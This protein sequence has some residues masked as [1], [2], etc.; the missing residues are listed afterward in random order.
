MHSLLL[1]TGE[2]VSD[3]IWPFSDHFKVESYKVFLDDD[4]IS[5]MADHFSIDKT[6]IETLCSKMKDWQRTEGFIENGK[7][8]WLSRENPH[9]KYDWSKVGG[10]FSGYLQ[11][12]EKKDPSFIGKLFGKKP[13]DK[14]NTALK[15]EISEGTIESDPPAAILHEG[16]WHECPMT[17]EENRISE[18]NKKAIEIYK[19]I[20][21]DMKL[22]VVDIH[23]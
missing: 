12:K 21:S 22:T 3:Q 13:S 19:S 10:R 16:T 20:P 7:I 6:D 1:V 5:L 11:L 17:S 18:W 2:K 8:Y 4:E 23:S 15:Y 9:G 14:V